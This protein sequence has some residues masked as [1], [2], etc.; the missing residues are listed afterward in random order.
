[1]D[2]RTRGDSLRPMVRARI[3]AS[4]AN[5]TPTHGETRE[6]SGWAM[7]M[8][9]VCRWVDEHIAPL[10][11]A[12]SLKD[13]AAVAW[14]ALALGGCGDAHRVEVEGTVRDGR[15]GAPV[16]HATVSTD[17]GRHAETDEEGVFV[18]ELDE[19]EATL[20][21][22]APGR[23]P[24]TE[25]VDVR[26]GMAP[27]RL[28]VFDALEVDA[29][30]HVGFDE[31][32]TLEARARCDAGAITWTQIGGPRLGDRM[33]AEDGRLH[34]RTHARRQLRD[35][36]DDTRADYR[37]EAR[38]ALRPT[39]SP[40]ARRGVTRVAARRVRVTASSARTD[41]DRGRTDPRVDYERFTAS[42]IEPF[43]DPSTYLP[44]A[45]AAYAADASTPL[46][47]PADSSN[48]MD[49]RCSSCHAVTP[50]LLLQEWLR[51]SMS[52]TTIER[53]ERDPAQ[54]AECAGCHVPGVSS[55]EPSASRTSETLRC[56]M[57]HGLDHTAPETQRGF[58]QPGL[59]AHPLPLYDAT[60]L[61]ADIP[62]RHLG[63]GAVCASCHR[64]GVANAEA[65]DRAPH[66][67][68]SDLLVGRGARG[69][70][71]LDDGAHRHIADSCARCHMTRPDA[72]DASYG[73]TGG[74][75]FAVRAPG[76]A[77]ISLAACAP[78]HGD[79]APERIG[80]RDWNGD[81][82]EGTVLEEHDAAIARLER[83]FSSRV[84][85]E[86]IRDLCGRVAVGISERDAR[87][88]LVDAEGALLG[89][90][91]DDGEFVGE[92][93][94]TVDALPGWLRDVAWDLSLLRAD[95]SRGL[96]NP[97][98]TFRVLRAARARLTE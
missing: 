77:S 13:G 76:S 61:I 66:A 85:A 27:L 95:G 8:S 1:M 91:D 69:I 60:V 20:T 49:D 93:A 74:H 21:A 23:C 75:S 96:H 67:P 51:A 81:G 47:P 94:V 68:Q 36:S 57:C 70:A 53:D 16:A 30:S 65:S 89:D 26:P 48:D 79:E 37:F 86:T 31:S 54:R 55:S 5:P 3:G 2:A 19:G 90:C 83:Q 33:R 40:G 58:Q 98:Y 44:Q 97:R 14:I 92:T 32:I 80:A 11:S 7:L 6:T 4:P 18:L 12:S 42:S 10:F 24:R 41:G 50:P 45:R 39:R 82:E 56:D 9:P 28:V 59:D 43:A 29:P 35:G 64:S 62:T 15:T 52:R 46:G 73:R 22:E 25:R 71:P 38:A 63:S 87:L 34:V 88:H 78:C 17:D 72:A 84:S